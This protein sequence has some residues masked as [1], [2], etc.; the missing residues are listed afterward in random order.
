M[1]LADNIICIH[2]LNSPNF[3]QL[4]QLPKTRGAMLFT[5]DIQ[6]TQSLTGEKNTVVRL[7]VAVKRKLQLYYWKGKKFEEFKDFELTVS[8]IPR[9]LSWYVYASAI[10]IKLCIFIE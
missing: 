7:C 4:Y 3:Q 2:D 10:R 1:P 5:L 8:D 6:S 9:E